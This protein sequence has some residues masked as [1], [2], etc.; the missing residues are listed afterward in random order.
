[1]HHFSSGMRQRTSIARGLIND[2]DLLIMDEPTRALDPVAAAEIRQIVK[3][4]V[5][6]DGRTVLIATNIMAEAEFL[7]DR[8]AFI[9][10]GQVQMTGSIDEM[11][12]LIENDD[13]YEIVVSK[14]DAGYVDDL[15]RLDGVVSAAADGDADGRTMIRLELRR[16]A[17][18]V[19]EAVRI[20]VASGADVWSCS[21]RELS[22]E[23]MFATLASRT[24]P[25][26]PARHLEAVPA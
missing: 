12:Y 14:F 15:R 20:I 8:L 17:P 22:V 11:R 2:P 19:P 25:A 1:M 26:P 6:Q 5:V 18:V 9:N 23:E 24:P 7:C 21:R 16:D 3:D 13:V 4:R 10:Q